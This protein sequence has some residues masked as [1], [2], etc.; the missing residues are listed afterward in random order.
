MPNASVKTFSEFD[1]PAPLA[2][3]LQI[4][5][6]EVP[7]PVQRQAIPPARDGLDV[8]ATAQTGTGKTAAFAL[9]FLDRMLKGGKKPVLVVAPTRELA[10]QI[11]SVLNQLTEETPQ[12]RPC[13][14]IG[15]AAYL[16]QIRGLRSQPMF[17][18]GTP[19]RL[20][21]QIERGNLDLSHFRGL[22]LDEAD[23]LL[24]MGFEPQLDE[25]IRHMPKE[26]QTLLFSATMAPKVERLA[27]R[28]MRD[29]VRIAVGAPSRPVETVSQEVIEVEPRE[30]SETLIREIDKVAGSIMV[31]TRTKL[32]AEAVAK[33]LDQA[34]HDVARIHG[35]R[36]QRQRSD[37]I[38]GFRSG[39]YRILV[40]TDVA[41]RGLDISHVRHVINYDLPTAPEDYVH[42]IGRTG[43]AG[44]E[45]R[46][47]AF[48]SADERWL[49]AKIYKLMYGTYPIGWDRK[50]S[51]PQKT[52]NQ[53]QSQKQK[54]GRRAKTASGESSNLANRSERRAKKFGNQKASAKRTSQSKSPRSASKPKRRR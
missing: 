9:P 17:V 22:V 1:F 3:A 37:A 53:K 52:S 16:K 11:A 30:K 45:G 19:G 10:E 7:T 47:L 29:P 42:R 24:D 36:T 15:G 31:F 13:V 8:I 4:M 33:T 51:R 44:A 49:W 39:R 26:R 5:G 32:R 46:A 20:I 41:A 6:Y 43:R 35:D 40:A 38:E 23:R 34:G 18:V 25:L 28:Y 27:K 21:D 14:I 54:P 48:V 2:R 12:L 50:K